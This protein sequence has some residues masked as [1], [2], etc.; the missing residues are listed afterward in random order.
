MLLTRTGINRRLSGSQESG[1]HYNYLR[2]RSYSQPTSE[3]EIEE[4]FGYRFPRFI[5]AGDTRVGVMLSATAAV[6]AGYESCRPSEIAAAAAFGHA[7]GR[8][9]PSA[10]ARLRLP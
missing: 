2:A 9:K 8:A 6:G 7:P 5:G 3:E 10:Q 4:S 1:E